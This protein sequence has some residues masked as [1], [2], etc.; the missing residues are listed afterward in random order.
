MARK[1]QEA[2][3]ME[4]QELLAQN[5]QKLNE[6]VKPDSMLAGIGKAATDQK[7]RSRVTPGP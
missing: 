2:V 3:A 6:P 5:A 4:Q 1:E 7:K